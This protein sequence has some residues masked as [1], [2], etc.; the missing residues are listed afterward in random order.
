MPVSKMIA[1]SKYFLTGLW[2]LCFAVSGRAQLL[3]WTADFPK[4]IDNIEITMDAS[5]GNQ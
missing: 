5:K 2:V 4:D 3:S 1:M